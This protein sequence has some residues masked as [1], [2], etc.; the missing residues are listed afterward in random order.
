VIE[1]KSVQAGDKTTSSTIVE[2]RKKIADA[3]EATDDVAFKRLQT[4]LQMPTDSTVKGAMDRDCKVRAEAVGGRLS[5]GGKAYK[6]ASLSATLDAKAT[7]KGIDAKLAAGLA[8]TIEGASSHVCGGKSYFVNKENDIGFHVIVLLAVGA[9]SEG[10]GFYL[11]FDPDVSATEESR[12]K[13]NV[14][15]PAST[16]VKEIADVD[17]SAKIVK[18]MLLGD[19]ADGFGPLIRKYYVDTTKKF[20]AIVRA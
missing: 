15:V 1:Q 17:E 6:P 8:V 9:D 5:T 3:V 7:W 16:K 10:N 19:S 13:W 12:T 11:G 2:I 20:P 14:V 4:W 18:A